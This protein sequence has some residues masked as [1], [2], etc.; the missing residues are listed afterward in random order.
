MSMIKCPDCGNKVSSRAAFSHCPYCGCPTTT[1]MKA[2]KTRAMWKTLGLIFLFGI[3]AIGALHDEKGSK[4]NAS[5]P[6]E[7]V[8][9][10]S[11]NQNNTSYREPRAPILKITDEEPSMENSSELE[12]EENDLIEV[13]PEENDLNDKAIEVPPSEPNDS[14]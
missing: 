8:I 14:I 11:V 4:P 9:K 6:K 2:A 7:T 5:K 13:I 3:I 1:I 10:Q 12:S